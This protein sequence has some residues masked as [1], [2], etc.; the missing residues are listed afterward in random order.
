M[1]RKSEN[2]W[3]TSKS[4]TVTGRVFKPCSPATLE[5]TEKL[6]SIR[7]SKPIAVLAS[8]FAEPDNYSLCDVTV[9]IAATNCS[10]LAW[11]LSKTT[12]GIF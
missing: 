12:K 2:P 10:K 1:R 9:V 11:A 7:E 3:L 8:A 5:S 6:M 4:L